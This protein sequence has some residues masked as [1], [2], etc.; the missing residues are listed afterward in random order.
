MNIV[1]T[2]G[3]DGIGLLTFDRAN[4]SANIFDRATLDEL[5]THL[6]A[7]ETQSVLRGVILV[8]AKPKIFIA[9]ADLHSLAGNLSSDAL[10][11]IVDL[12]HRIFT[13]L[14]RLPVPSVAAIHGVCLGGGCELALACDW[15]IASTDKAT[16]IGLPETQL[17]ILP[18]WGGSVRLPA[19]IGLP[20]A[21]N[22]ILTGKQLAGAPALKAGLVDELAHPE[23]LLAA[24]RRLLARGKRPPLK[25]AL[26]SCAP[27]KVLVA[28]KARRKVLAKTRG[29]YPAPLKAIDVCTAA[30]GRPRE[31]ALAREKAGF[32]E[33]VHTPEARNLM[34]LYFLQERAKKFTPP[35][36]AEAAPVRRVAVVGAGVMGAGIA[37]WVSARGIPVLLK[38]VDAAA[39]ARGLHSIGKVY[40]DAVR[41]HV[42]TAAEARAGF[43][44]V[45][46]V[47][48]DVS[49]AGFDLV[50]EA[51]VEKLDL[52]QRI[53]QQLE[54]RARPDTVLATNTSALSIE[55]I[56]TGLAY[57]DRVIGLHFFNPVHRMQLLEIV[58]GP[59]TSTATVATAVQ[60]AK[61][62]G[63]LPVLVN[64][65]PGFVVNRILMPYLVEAVRLFEMGGAV[66]DL[67]RLMLDFG[68]PMGPL[69]L[70]DEVGL[71]VALH[72]AKDLERRLPH[73]VPLNDTLERMIA[74]GWLGKKSGRGF[75]L[76]G[77]KDKPE[78]PNPDVRSVQIIPAE[79]K[80]DAATRLDRL[81]LLMV[82]EA[83]RCLEENV[84]AAPEDIDFAMIFGTGWAPFRG[85]PLRH[86]DHLGAAEVVR[87]LESLLRK[88][89]PHFAPCEKLQAMAR[90]GTQFYPS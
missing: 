12:G 26:L 71:D 84:V 40:H 32:L 74:K 57:P 31:D 18:A 14:E 81:V 11:A 83:A 36:P 88:A 46:P 51:A 3:P 87:R 50:I 85:G 55:S 66:R 38:D 2:L 37:Q 6:A 61:T 42:F 65:S 77:P 63:K 44:R 82:N 1:R 8:S 19:L 29:H 54:A 67:D 64:D 25:R 20:A 59:H 49:L 48:T 79:F 56:S 35:A 17:G 9:G 23:Y 41:H 33:L 60:F 39:L 76:H 89:A 47:Q 78:T 45:T 69:R 75:Y 73:P 10:G 70:C 13:R 22:L 30:L 27:F 4:S 21:L 62:L 90:D 53:F 43:D 5:D 80:T 28:W 16:K 58:R 24:A 72:V 15:R 52:K 7:L 34:N 68:M 86:A